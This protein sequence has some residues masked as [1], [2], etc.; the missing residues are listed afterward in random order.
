MKRFWT[1]GKKLDKAVI[2][3]E[4]NDAVVWGQ[5]P[6]PPEANGGFKAEPPFAFGGWGGNWGRAPV[7]EFFTVLF[8]KIRN[9]K[10]TLVKIYA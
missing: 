4:S 1:L 6:Q 10:H 9:F 3:G 2:V 8:Q 5:S 7:S